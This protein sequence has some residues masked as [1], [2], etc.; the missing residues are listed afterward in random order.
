MFDEKRSDA[1][2]GGCPMAKGCK[3]VKCPNC[4]YETPPEDNWLNNILKK[5]RKQK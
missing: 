2:C 3:L 1:S 4:G 5:R